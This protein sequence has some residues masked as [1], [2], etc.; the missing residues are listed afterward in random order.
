MEQIKTVKNRWNRKIYQVVEVKD[1]EVILE[2][3][4]GTQFTITKSEY[5]FN[6][7]EKSS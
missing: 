1:S 3:E 5:F 2:R 6:Y 4:D 7:V